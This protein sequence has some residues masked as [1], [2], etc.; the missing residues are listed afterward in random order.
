MLLTRKS[1]SARTA[2]SA[3]DA[4]R[5]RQAVHDG[6]PDVPQALRP[7]R[8]RRRVR[9]PA[10]VR[11][12]RPGRRPRTATRASVENEAHGLHALLGR[13]RGRRH[14]RERRVDAAGAGVRVADQPGRA[15]RQGRV[16]ARARHHRAFAPAEDADEARQRQVAAAVVGPGDRTRSATR[17]SRSARNPVPTRC[18]GSAAP[19]TTTSRRT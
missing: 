11:R 16:G 2:G 10:A 9:E 7:R 12:D 18:S 13:L 15:L 19:S 6:P 5:G 14:R 4:A 17:C 3:P 1:D 8:R